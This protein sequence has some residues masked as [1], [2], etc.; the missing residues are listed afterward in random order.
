MSEEITILGVGSRVNHPAYGAG[1]IVGLEV[2]A[3]KVVFIQH[4]LKMVGKHY[5]SWDVVEAIKEEEI[6]SFDKFEKSLIKILRKWSDVSEEVPMAL[7]WNDGLMILKPGDDD[8]Q[9]KEIPI[10]VF[11]HKIV[12][13]R[14]RL[15]VMEQ[16][17]NSSNLTEAEKVNLQQ[18]ISRIY[19]SLTTFNILFR[20]K[21]DSF[22]GDGKR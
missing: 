3:Y 12:M 21:G 6:S 2:A 13:V 10:E 15:R 7:K 11:F 22:V 14:D 8:L 16:R 4:G 18:Y 9:S 1:V 19:G 17:V 5:N 20:E